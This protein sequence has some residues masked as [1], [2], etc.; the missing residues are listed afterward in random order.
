MK[1]H[2]FCSTEIRCHGFDFYGALVGKVTWDEMTF[3]MIRGERPSPRIKR[4]FNL[5]LVALSNPG[6]RDWSTRAAM[7]AAIGKASVG[8]CLTAGL[9]VHQGGVQGSQMVEETMRFL[10]ALR[11]QKNLLQ[12]LSRQKDVPPGYGW[13]Y[14]SK[15]IRAEMMLKAARRIMKPG[16]Y[17]LLASQV[18]IVISEKQQG[19]LTLPGVVGALLLDLGFS[20]HEGAGLFLMAAMPGW[21][22]HSLEQRPKRWNEYPVYWQ[23]ERYHYQ[24]PYQGKSSAREFPFSHVASLQELRGHI[25]TSTGATLKD[26]KDF[27]YMGHRQFRDLT[28]KIS[29][30]QHLILSM[31][32]RRISKKE[33]RFLEVLA[34]MTNY[35]DPRLWMHQA[36]AA[37]TSMG[38]TPGQSLVAGLATIE[39]ERL[40]P[41][42]AHQAAE[43][44]ATVHALHEKSSLGKLLEEKLAQGGTFFGY[45][46]PLVN[47]DERIPVVMQFARRY[48]YAKGTF[49]QLSFQIERWIKRKKGIVLNAAGL[50]SALMLDLGYSPREIYAF[51]CSA[52]TGGMHAMI[53]EQN[54]REPGTFLPMA[55]EDIEYVGRKPRVLGRL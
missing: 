5:V 50:T 37:A 18:E 51:W 8:N 40:G 19:W 38:C 23:P 21:L 47:T 26:R 9:S 43:F 35:G 52:F 44:F 30:M 27:E 11:P 13:W 20:P 31:T 46:R 1:G 28:G 6:P 49:V 42:P 36:A 45:G 53:W 33:G 16:P 4:L 32:G 2:P 39:G 25:Y 24:P 29:W 41:S 3:L 14:T 12:S 34:V 55:C 15:D 54:Q 7:G 22:A 48:G 10:H 17:T